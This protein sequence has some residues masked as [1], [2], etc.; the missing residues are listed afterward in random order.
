MKMVY[1]EAIL[2][3][4]SIHLSHMISGFE[5]FFLSFF[6]QFTHSPSLNPQYSTDLSWELISG[7]DVE[8]SRELFLFSNQGENFWFVT[9]CVINVIFLRKISYKLILFY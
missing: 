5:A 6:F 4:S 2:G 3:L 9:L 1:A 7:K 8:H